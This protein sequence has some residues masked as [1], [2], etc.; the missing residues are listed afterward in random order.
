MHDTRLRAQ[1][2]AAE[3]SRLKREVLSLK[4]QLDSRT[5]LL[6]AE[7]ETIQDRRRVQAELASESVA[8]K[9]AVGAAG[10]DYAAA[11]TALRKARAAVGGERVADDEDYCI[12]Q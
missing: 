12:V 9:A 11:V 5:E 4:L 7:T 3:V 2:G 1:S 8:V 6:I 10:D